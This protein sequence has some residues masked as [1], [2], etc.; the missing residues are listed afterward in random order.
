MFGLE[1]RVKPYWL[2]SSVDRTESNK[3]TTRT[4]TQE[5]PS[6]Y[7]SDIAS[8]VHA[9]DAE[10]VAKHLDI[11]SRLE[12]SALV[13]EQGGEV[14]D[15]YCDV[16]WE[17]FYENNK[18]KSS[19]LMKIDNALYALLNSPV[20][21]QKG[22]PSKS[23]H[24]YVL[25]VGAKYGRLDVVEMMLSD[26]YTSKVGVTYDEECVILQE[27]IK[28]RELGVAKLIY[29]RRVDPSTSDNK[30]IRS[31]SENG[32][33]GMVKL[34]LNN[35]RVDPSAKNNEALRKATLKGHAEI[36]KL[37][38]TDP[39]VDASVNNGEPLRQAIKHNYP[40]V[41]EVLLQDECV[42]PSS[43]NKSSNAKMISWAAYNGH[44]AIVKMLLNDKRV[45]PAVTDQYALQKAILHGHTE[46]MQLLL[47]HESMSVTSDIL[48]VADH[49]STSAQAFQ[50]ILA[51]RP[52]LWPKL[53]TIG[54][55]CYWDGNISNELGTL[56]RQS[57]RVLLLCVKRYFTARVAAR[58]NDV[59][60]EVCDEWNRFNIEFLDSNR[61]EYRSFQEDDKFSC[62][63]DWLEDGDEG[64]D[65]DN[66]IAHCG[67]V[68]NA[69]W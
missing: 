11:C 6:G 66:R 34:L 31:A 57:S 50:A 16:P 51:V 21:G 27:A 55:K 54:F 24:T 23:I 39:R 36:V 65:E 10:L 13:G 17:L 69:F 19:E 41:A 60:R 49:T 52:V 14:P 9:D 56:E 40:E 18:S 68:D 63:R 33:V 4:M 32:D 26:R 43:M 53:T 38:T 8:A 30:A 47:N 42:D 2:V 22:L 15:K 58:V 46:I 45:D 64:Y 3:I 7:R 48:R 61:Y 20:H 44:L 35:S 62:G 59:L 5:L 29:N 1:H 67:W 12:R 28:C 25:V 37:L